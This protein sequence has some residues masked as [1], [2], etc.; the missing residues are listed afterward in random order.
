[1]EF[2]KEFQFKVDSLQFEESGEKKSN[3]DPD[4]QRLKPS[5]Y[6]FSFSSEKD[7]GMYDAINRG[8]KLAIGGSGDQALGNNK[9]RSNG[10]SAA[11]NLT[12]GAQRLHV[13]SVIA[14]LNCDEQYLPGALE[15]V[16]RWFSDHPQ[17]D[18]CFGD[19]LVVDGKGQL[20]CGRRMV[21]PSRYHI[22]TDQLPL[23]S[24][25]MFIRAGALKKYRLFPDAAW[26]NTGDVE[27]ILRMLSQGVRYGFLNEYISAFTD[28][29][30]NL[31]LDDQAA[32]EYDRLRQTAPWWVR[33]LRVLWVLNHRIRKLRAGCYHLEPL[34]Y[35]IYIDSLSQRHGFSEARPESRWLSRL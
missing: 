6:S 7:E 17:L 34:D 25:A 8:F 30:E 9:V 28:T 27:L 24:A 20:I 4:A 5:A 12:P 3:V 16:A 32:V 11:E 33:R 22:V 26:K 23:Y 18:I 15:K 10:S 14:W 19:V 21:R 2:L 13:D 35:S 31:A 29:G 1:M